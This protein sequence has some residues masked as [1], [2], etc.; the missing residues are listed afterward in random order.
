MGTEEKGCCQGAW[1]QGL[2]F[3]ELHDFPACVYG[4]LM[5]GVGLCPES[6]VTNQYCSSFQFL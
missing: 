2:N 3:G 1:E 4:L 6:Q 5:E